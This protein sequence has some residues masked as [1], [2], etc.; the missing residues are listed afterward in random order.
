MGYTINNKEQIEIPRHGILFTFAN[1]C[2]TFDHESAEK[3]C[4]KCGRDFCYSC[5]MDHDRKYIP[6]FMECP[7]CG[8]DYYS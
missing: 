7:A 1:P 3:T 6:E 8:H 5:C 4:P 2:R